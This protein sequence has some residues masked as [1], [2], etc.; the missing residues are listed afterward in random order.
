M[1]IKSVMKL[2]IGLGGENMNNEYKEDIKDDEVTVVIGFCARCGGVI[3]EYGRC[4]RCGY[5]TRCD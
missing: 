5:C 1:Y 3:D 2:E 4:R